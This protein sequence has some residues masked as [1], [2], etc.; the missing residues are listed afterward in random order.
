MCVCVCVSVRERERERLENRPFIKLM[1]EMNK[2][3]SF[4]Q[5]FFD[6]ECLRL[7]LFC[8][9]KSEIDFGFGSEAK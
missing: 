4:E 7:E 1:S 2:R 6:R 5:I 9:K 3:F 8:G